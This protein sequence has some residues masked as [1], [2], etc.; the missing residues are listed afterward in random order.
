MHRLILGLDGVSH[1]VAE[2][3]HR[4]RDG[5]NNR[6]AN[7]RRID[8]GGNQRNTAP[9]SALGEKGVRRQWHRWQAYATVD[10]RYVHL[11]MY[12]SREEARAARRAFEEQFEP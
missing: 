8:H 5:L 1:R 3:D 12:G 2:V 9:R 7:L 6:R 10:G 11:G 4:D